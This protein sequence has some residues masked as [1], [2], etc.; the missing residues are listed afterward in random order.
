MGN[1]WPKLVG[2]LL[3]VGIGI[4]IYK[5]LGGDGT[6]APP[7]RTVTAEAAPPAVAGAVQAQAVA[8]QAEATFASV[9]VTADDFV[10]GKADAPITIVEYASLTCPHC[11]DFH[12]NVLPEIKK[13]FID[14]G[15]ARLVYRDYPLDRLALVGSMIAQCAGRDRYFGF[16][17]VMFRSQSQWARSNN[18]GEE[19]MKIAR[20][21]GMS[22]ADFDGCLKN[23]DQQKA[24]LQ[25]QLEGSNKY[26]VNS[27]PTILVNGRKYPG[28]LSLPQMKT[29]LES[30][31][32][33]QK[34]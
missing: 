23:E 2:V 11:A 16:L 32:P 22:Q 21:G 1:I 31:A 28:G 12:N 5:G 13:D 25:K 27:T 15:K 9:E 4:A 24:I 33:A 17:D 7:R 26:K 18:P 19:L 34:S 10:L 30:I 3:V 20:L 14:T 29:L 6:V 8:P